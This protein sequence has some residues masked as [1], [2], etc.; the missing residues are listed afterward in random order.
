MILRI[1]IALTLLISQITEHPL[2]AEVSLKFRG[3]SIPDPEHL[4][5]HKPGRGEPGAIP[6][7]KNALN[8]L[9]INLIRIPVLP[10]DGGKEGF[11]SNPQAYYRHH[12]LPLLNEAKKR[13][14]RV[15]VDAHFVDDFIEKE[16]EVKLFWEK[17]GQLTNG[18]NDIIFQIYNEATTPHDWALY[19]QK[20]I[21][22]VIE[23]IRKT[24]PKNLLLI[25]SPRWNTMMDQ[26]IKDPINKKNIAYTLHIYP[27]EWSENM[28][29]E[30]YETLAKK[31]PF[32]LSEWGYTSSD[33]FPKLQGTVDGYAR[34]LLEKISS[35]PN[36]LGA[37]AW[38]YD[39]LWEPT[40][41]D[42]KGKKISDPGSFSDYLWETW[43][44]SL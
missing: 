11:L 38:N 32:I 18:R 6:V 1:T 3:V 40:L 27:N 15:I 13:K 37:I 23:I 29:K 12:L 31:F 2:S 24:H 36:C 30:R 20:I 22:P 26:V 35:Y 25:G 9:N 17:M 44:R 39:S 34:P 19:K 10:G 4:N 7:L 28:W 16:N 42:N 8:D 33:Q 41:L 5:S 14:I 43:G 21:L